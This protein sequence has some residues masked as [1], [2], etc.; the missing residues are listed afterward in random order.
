MANLLDETTGPVN[1]NG[2]EIHVINRQLPY[3]TP[4]GTI[5]AFGLEELI[6]HSYELMPDIAKAALA[7]SQKVNDSIT[8]RAVDRVIAVAAASAA[9]IGATPC[10]F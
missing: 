6:E 3:E 9:T 7:S 1:Q 10:P 5:P 8:K 4:I 2:R